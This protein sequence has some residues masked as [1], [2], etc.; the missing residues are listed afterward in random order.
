M[1]AEIILVPFQ[2]PKPEWQGSTFSSRS[3]G[4]GTQGCT[5]SKTRA[6]LPTGRA[7]SCP[8]KSQLP[9]QQQ[10]RKTEAWEAKREA[11]RRLERDGLS[12]SA[13]L[14]RGLRPGLQALVLRLAG[15][16]TRPPPQSGGVHPL[17]PG[18]P[19]PTAHTPLPVPEASLLRSLGTRS[20][21][22]HLLQTN[23][24]DLESLW[25]LGPWFR[26]LY[27]QWTWARV[28]CCAGAALPQM[29]RACA[30]GEVLGQAAPPE[31]T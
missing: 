13:A 3:L 18:S 28:A 16:P 9:E 7:A 31:G 4:S 23:L 25:H 1:K 17:N 24:R 22:T 6:V 14:E 2:N 27:A 10:Q 15:A 19:Y 8:S 11:A 20:P 21:H 12:P 26:A 29:A 5:A 30:L